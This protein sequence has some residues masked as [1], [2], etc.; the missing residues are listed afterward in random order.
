MK[1]KDMISKLDVLKFIESLEHDLDSNR[2]CRTFNEMESPAKVG[3]LKAQLTLIQTTIGVF[4]EL[5]NITREHVNDFDE[6]EEL[7]IV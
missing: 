5:N 7:R 4:K 2:F 3:V 1:Q 6:N